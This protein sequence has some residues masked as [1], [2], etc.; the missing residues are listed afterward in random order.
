MCVS[1]CTKIYLYTICVY[2]YIYIY[3]Y[4]HILNIY[5]RISTLRL[6]LLNDC[7]GTLRETYQL[8]WVGM[9]GAQVGGIVWGGL[10][11]GGG[12]QGCD[13]HVGVGLGAHVVG[14][15]VGRGEGSKKN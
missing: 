15:G 9:Q 3:S 14:V 11:W 13:V 2:I 1:N 5:E 7:P 4:V 6:Y 10:G 12:V 8:R